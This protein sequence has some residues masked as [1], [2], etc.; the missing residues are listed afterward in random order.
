MQGLIGL[1][2]LIAFLDPLPGPALALGGRGRLRVVDPVLGPL[3]GEAGVE[4]ASRVE[5]GGG[6]VDHRQGRDRCQMGRRRRADEELADPAVGDAGHSHPAVQH[7]GLAGD[8]LHHVVAVQALQLLEEVEGAAGAAGAAH[9]HVDHGEAE[10]VEDL[11]DAA[12]GAGRVGVAVARV[13]D[14][15]RV[16]AGGGGARQPHVDRQAGSIPRGQ[17]SVASGGQRLVVDRRVL[18]RGAVAHHSDGHGERAVGGADPV[19]LAGRDSAEEDPAEAADGLL[20]NRLALAHQAQAGTGL[21]AG[22]VDL[23]DAPMDGQG[24]R[25]GRRRGHQQDEGERGQNRHADPLRNPLSPRPAHSLPLLGLGPWGP[26]SILRRSARR[27]D[28]A[29]RCARRLRPSPRE[30]S[31]SAGSGSPA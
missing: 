2:D 25:G 8:G 26:Q 30:C 9:V 6:V 15:G 12:L 31:R 21:G 20:G 28:V 29:T 10:Q 18:R 17:V 27:L 11:A 13:L 4:E 19:A 24:V 23:V 5:G 3:H 14:Q 7:P 16:G 22:D 1:A